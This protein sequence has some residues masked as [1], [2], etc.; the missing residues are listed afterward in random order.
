MRFYVSNDLNEVCSVWCFDCNI[1]VKT[2]LVTQHF[3]S[4]HLKKFVS[5]ETLRLK[6][7]P[8][9]KF[10]FIETLIA[11]GY[12]VKNYETFHSCYHCGDVMDLSERKI[13]DHLSRTKHRG[14]SG[15]DWKDYKKDH[16][17]P[18]SR[19]VSQFCVAASGL[20]WSEI[21]CQMGTATLD[22]EDGW[23]PFQ[24]TRQEMV[25]LSDPIVE[26]LICQTNSWQGSVEQFPVQQTLQQVLARVQ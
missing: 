19:G 16:L 23:R 18:I 24:V 25:D 4:K 20:S 1:A 14:V 21:V 8:S 12:V 13:Y 5:I 7:K 10:V 17:V 3:K 9:K 26:K 2:E 11:V 22:P 15:H 6:S